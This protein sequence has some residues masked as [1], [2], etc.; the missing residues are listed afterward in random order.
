[1]ASDQAKTIKG[2]LTNWE[3]EI[4]EEGKADVGSLLKASGSRAAGPLLF[5]PALVMISPI[6]AIPGVPIVLTTLTFLVAGQLVVGRSA[7]W[8]P[9]FVRNRGLPKKKVTSTIDKLTPYAERA[10]RYL[11]QRL[12]LLAG[13]TASRIV[14]AFCIFLSLLVYPA[15]L[16][17]FAVALPGSAIL[18][19]SLGLLVRDGV[20]TMVGLIVALAAVATVVYW[21]V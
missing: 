16:L 15:T 10:D 3:D 14:A 17:P 2:V 12:S 5:L 20:V 21:L 9:S 18:L 11:G 4:E 7:I 19:L 8:L 13:E 1:M 6:G